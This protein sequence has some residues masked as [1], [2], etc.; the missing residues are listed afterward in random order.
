VTLL[1][2][3]SGILHNSIRDPL[4]AV[5]PCAPT[6]AKFIVRWLPRNHRAAGRG[7]SER[8]DTMIERGL[9]S[10]VEAALRVRKVQLKEEGTV[11]G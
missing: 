3:P 9:T 10:V 6:R 11:A 2:Y 7:K 5:S 1:G 4:H 8:L